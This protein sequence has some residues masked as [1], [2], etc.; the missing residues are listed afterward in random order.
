MT[1]T[2]GALNLDP[3]VA[4]SFLDDLDRPTPSVNDDFPKLPGSRLSCLVQRARQAWKSCWHGSVPMQRRGSSYIPGLIVACL[5][6]ALLYPDNRPLLDPDEGRHAQIARTMWVTGDWIV[7]RLQRT[8]YYEK[9]PLQYWLTIPAYQWFGA[10]PWVARLAPALAAWLTVLMTF[11]WANRALGTRVAF[12]G[13]VCLC[14]TLEFVVLGRTLVVDALLTLCVMASSFAAHNAVSGKS[15]RWKWWLGSALMC[16]MGI[17]TKGPV[18]LILVAPP[19]AAYHWLTGSRLSRRAGGVWLLLVLLVAA[20]W[21]VAMAWREPAY[22]SDFFW[23]ANVLRYTDPSDHKQAWWFYMPVLFVGTFPWCLLWPALVS[24]VTSRRPELARRR[25]PALGY[26]L[27]LFVWP[28]VFFSL[29][30]C[31]S[32]PY[33]LPAVVPLALATGACMETLLFMPK[34]SFGRIMAHARG[35]LPS[36][37]TIAVLLLTAA[38]YVTASWYGWLRTNLAVAIAVPTCL[39]VA[40]W[41]CRRRVGPAVGWSLCAVACFG[42]GIL[43]CRQVYAAFVE[44]RSPLSALRLVHHRQNVPPHGVISADRVWYSASFYLGH[45]VEAYYHDAVCDWL[46]SIMADERESIV[47]VPHDHRLVDLR[48][49]LS[50]AALSLHYEVIVPD[51]TSR[52]ALV[53]C[54]RLPEFQASTACPESDGSISDSLARGLNQHNSIPKP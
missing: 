39:A 18:A 29:A 16:G 40:C 52:V 11:I 24:F 17:L 35:P 9:P 38:T 14:L 36:Y 26:C 1:A 51:P 33:M 49:R 2:P 32:P 54:K 7:P 22:V 4:R 19:L 23:K 53:V 45:T 37:G 27:L 46:R 42:F 30:G 50:D 10:L 3:P 20:P 6:L 8:P 21:Y 31:K 15:L 43:P 34:R 47:L 28:V 5:A 44:H 25:R 41:L 48:A 12:L 13:S